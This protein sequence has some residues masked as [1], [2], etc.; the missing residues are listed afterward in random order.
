MVGMAMSM[1]DGGMAMSMGGGGEMSGMAMDG[2]D[3]PSPSVPTMTVLSFVA[4]A[5]RLGLAFT[6]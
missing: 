5:A 4:L 6:A 2:A 3:K 1:G